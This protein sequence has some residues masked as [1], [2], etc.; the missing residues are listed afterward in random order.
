MNIMKEYGLSLVKALGSFIVL[1]LLLNLVKNTEWKLL[2]NYYL[3]SNYI[4]LYPFNQRFFEKKEGQKEEATEQ[5]SRTQRKNYTESDHAAEEEPK[6]M[7]RAKAAQA[8]KNDPRELLLSIGLS[9]VKYVFL[10]IC[11]PIIFMQYYL[12]GKDNY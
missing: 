4:M 12:L 3:I 11:A 2:L 5:L 8:N 9:F 6:T 10:I 1:L 7:S